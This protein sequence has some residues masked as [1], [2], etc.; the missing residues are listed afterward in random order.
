MKERTNPLC[1]IRGFTRKRCVHPGSLLRPRM[2]Q[3]VHHALVRDYECKG[4]STFIARDVNCF[5]C[6]HELVLLRE[7]F[8]RRKTVILGDGPNDWDKEP[9]RK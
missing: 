2:G 4:P 3:K 8:R 6:I 7:L 5:R 1:S 9:E